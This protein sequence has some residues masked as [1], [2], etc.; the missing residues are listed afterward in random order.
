MI[1]VR[2]I[3]QMTEAELNALPGIHDI[4]FEDGDQ[5]R[6]TRNET[7]YSKLFWVIF[8]DY[9]RAKILKKH[10]VQSVL[11]GEALT[12]NTHLKLCSRILRSIVEDEQLIYPEQKEPLL[13]LIYRTISHAMNKLSMITEPNVVSID[14]LDFIQIAKDP[15]VVGLQNEARAD[16]QNKIKYAYHESIK[17][18]RTNPLFKDNGLAKAVR[19]KMV[20][21]NQVT[22]CVVLRGFPTEV[23][24]AIYPMP[25]L[26]NYTLGNTSF[27]NFVSDSR[28]AAKS[29]YYADAALQDSEYMARK[30]QLFTSVVERIEHCD[31][32]STKYFQWKV[33]GPEL[34]AAGVVSYQGDLP[35]LVGKNYL[36]EET[37]TLRSI[38]G[39]EKH[40]IGKKIKL[41][42]VI[43]CQLENPHHVCSVCAGRL[44][45]NVSR[46]A[47]I[48][49]LGASTMNRPISQSVLSI[50]H[51]NTSSTMVKIR[52]SDH[53]AA[54]M[55]SGTTGSAF[56]LHK[57]LKPLQPK[58]I[59][60]R[61]EAPGLVDLDSDMSLDSLILSR[62]SQLTKVRLEIKQNQ[63]DTS[64]VLNV[65]QKAKPSMMSQELLVYL[66]KK[67]WTIDDRND[68]VIDMSDWNYQDP[69]FVMPNNEDSFV[70][71]AKAVDIMVRA[72]QEMLEQR[73]AA[74]SAELLLR[75]LFNIVNAKLKVNIF[76][77]EIIVYSLMI[78]S[79]R[80]YAMAR[81]APSPVLGIG[82]NVI[83]YRSLGAAMAYEDQRRAI[84]NPINFFQ[85]R[86]PD[87]PMD[88]FFTPQEVIDNLVRR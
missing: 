26:S 35:M 15:V 49:H 22:Q 54:F 58:L 39:N 74:D 28:T 1:P 16:P 47:N 25:N 68:F 45:E 78:E 66:K 10:H 83:G 21:D 62:V 85:G 50:K 82:D 43:H 30:F 4:L 81:N 70:D 33:Q 24:G 63:R 79:N 71:L 5:G 8:K 14:I 38:E 34:D 77:M 88:V 46:F 23:D 76:P 42:T 40:L 31:C 51:V 44:S 59:I 29:H 61:D 20:K 56:C 9:P 27:Y 13:A 7:I 87:S 84:T 80:S 69:L 75:D 86:R 36:D 48:G 41:R 3:L 73:L 11:K 12:S 18:I 60:S 65:T 52:L 32:G 37:N 6:S 67:K 57:K 55:N 2:E 19:A 64:V 72:N 17:F 53:E